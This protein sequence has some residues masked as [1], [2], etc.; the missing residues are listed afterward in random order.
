MQNAKY[1]EF[2]AHKKLHVDFVAKLGALSAPLKPEE[3]NF[4]K[5]W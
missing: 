2:D 4:A 5:S 1:S 3:V